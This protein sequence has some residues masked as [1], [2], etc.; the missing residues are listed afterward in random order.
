MPG[1]FLSATHWWEAISLREMFS[2]A[3]GNWSVMECLVM[4]HG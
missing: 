1:I 2:N 3:V 4:P